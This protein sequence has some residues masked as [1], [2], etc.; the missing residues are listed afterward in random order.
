M[1][2]WY[3][4]MGER[5]WVGRMSAVVDVWMKGR[6]LGLGIAGNVIIHGTVSII[7]TNAISK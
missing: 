5:C 7:C 1:G 4:E 3:G 6:F 2:L